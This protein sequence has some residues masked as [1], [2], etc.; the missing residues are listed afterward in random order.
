MEANQPGPLFMIIECPTVDYIPSLVTNKQLN[1]YWEE[2]SHVM[3]AVIIH[4]T[5]MI[6]FENE[7]YNQW[8]ERQVNPLG[9]K[10]DQHQFSP[11]NISRSSRVKVMRITKFVT[12]ERIL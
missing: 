10:R 12:K 8:R 3:P 7:E 2:N 1:Q 11:N 4:L 5:P 9:P 6:V